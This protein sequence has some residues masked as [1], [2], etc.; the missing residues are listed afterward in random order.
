MYARIL[1]KFTVA[2][3]AQLLRDK[4]SEQMSIA[5]NRKALHDFFIEDKFE[6]GLVLE[7]WEVK[8]IRA[9]SVQLKDSYV[10]IMDGELWLLGCD[11]APSI[12]VSSHVIPERGRSKKLL[13][14]KREIDKLTVKVEQKG[15]S[16]VA[17]NLHYSKG[18]VKADIA[19]A[20]GKKLYDKRQTERERS[21]KQETSK[22]IKEYKRL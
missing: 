4:D 15:Y 20:K 17:L 1:D 13:L 9:G 3:A 6:A 16:I 7:G 22:I 18:R 19:L 21:A 11:I 8:S 5:D 10:K 14:N 2:V 12:T